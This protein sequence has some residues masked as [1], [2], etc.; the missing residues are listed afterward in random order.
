MEKRTFIIPIIKCGFSLIGFCE[1]EERSFL[2][3]CGGLWGLEQKI[4]SKQFVFV[5]LFVLELFSF[6][7]TF[8]KGPKC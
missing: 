8:W 5:F 6:F 2:D 4:I 1:G 7:S 3:F